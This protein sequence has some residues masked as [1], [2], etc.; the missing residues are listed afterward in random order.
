MTARPAAVT[1]IS[2]VQI[3][4]AALGVFG[5][6]ITFLLINNPMMR[7]AL[8]RNHAPVPVQ[9]AMSVASLAINLS[10]AIGFLN[11]QNW[12]RFVFV[13]WSVLA[14]IYTLV[15]VALSAWIL[16]PGLVL[17][18]ITAVIV[19]LPDANRYFSGKDDATRTSAE[20]G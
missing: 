1:V 2:W 3:V 8:A 11:R 6:V 17:P 19:F 12:A 5:M 7:D 16:V 20:T 15:V 18:V 14:I 13:G 4:F 9:L 10:C